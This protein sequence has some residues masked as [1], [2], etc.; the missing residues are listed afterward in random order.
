MKFPRAA[1]LAAR[2]VLV[3]NDDFT[4]NHLSG[5]LPLAEFVLK[6]RMQLR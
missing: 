4:Q 5:D 3:V 1:A 2:V 6:Q